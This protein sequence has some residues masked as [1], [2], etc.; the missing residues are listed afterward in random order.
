MPEIFK[1][2][3]GLVDPSGNQSSGILI[4]PF[5]SADVETGLWTWMAAGPFSDKR[6]ISCG[7]KKNGSYPWQHSFACPV[8]LFLR[9]HCLPH[10]GR[11]ELRRFQLGPL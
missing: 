4:A 3:A 1:T 11:Q 8:S 2:I 6:L 9:F 5:F 7:G 10:D